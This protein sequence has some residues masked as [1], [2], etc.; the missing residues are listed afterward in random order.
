MIF[1]KAMNNNNLKISLYN[2]SLYIQNSN[3]CINRLEIK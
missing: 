2:T 1:L 3:L